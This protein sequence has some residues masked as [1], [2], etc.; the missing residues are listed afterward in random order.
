MTVTTKNTDL[1]S[2]KI[3]I[4]KGIAIILMLWGHCIQYCTVGGG[5]TGKILCFK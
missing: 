3:N 4:L 5:G 1:T 2:V